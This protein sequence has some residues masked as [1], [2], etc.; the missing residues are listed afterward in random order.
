[1]VGARV[2]PFPAHSL[3]IDA[4][5]FQKYDEI[6]CICLVLKAQ[7]TVRDAEMSQLL[8]FA[9]YLTCNVV[10]SHELGYRLADGRVTGSE[11]P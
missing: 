7:E 9:F 8:A 10:S 5:T 2:R 1:M 11:F 6:L 4:Q 3:G